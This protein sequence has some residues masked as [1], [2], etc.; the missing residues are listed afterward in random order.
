MKKA[1][2]KVTLRFSSG[3]NIISPESKGGDHGEKGEEKDV[4]CSLREWRMS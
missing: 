1:Y 3:K 2:V 4:V